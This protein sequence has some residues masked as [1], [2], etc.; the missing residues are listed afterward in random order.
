[1]CGT[2]HWPHNSHVWNDIFAEGACYRLLIL[3]Q[4]PRSLLCTTSTPPEKKERI[5]KSFSACLK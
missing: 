1:M 2:G 4:V 3:G 5:V